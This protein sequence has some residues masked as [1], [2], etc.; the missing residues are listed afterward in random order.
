MQVCSSTAAEE[1]A[2]F[3]VRDYPDFSFEIANALRAD[4]IRLG[5]DVRAEFWNTVLVV[6]SVQM[7]S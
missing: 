2:A 3:L 7:V 1:F 6:L 5:N 4:A